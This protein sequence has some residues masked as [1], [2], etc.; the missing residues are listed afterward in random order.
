MK[1]RS[2]LG[3]TYRNPIL[4]A[5]YS[6]PDVIRVG[7]NF[8]MTA[9]SF[10]YTPGLPILVSKDLV[11]WELK[12]YALENIGQERFGIPRH[13]EGVWAPAI[14]YH[15][16]MFYIYYGMPDEGYYV[17]RTK[18]PLGKWEEPVCVLEGKGLIDPC[19]FRDDDGKAYIIHGYAKSRIGFKSIL[20]IFEMS[21]DGLKAVSE[22]HFIFDGNDPAHPAVTI[23]GPKVYKRNGYY[24]ILAP[25]G[26]VK[27]GYQVALRSRNIKGPYE[28][29]TVM[30][31]GS[32]VINGPHQGGLVDTPNGDE[33]FIHFQDRGLYG[34]ICHLQPASWEEDWPVI[35]PGGEPVYE[36]EKPACGRTSEMIADENV[37]ENASV[38]MDAAAENKKL[39]QDTFTGGEP[40]LEWQ[41]LG[42]HRSS[43]FGKA[44][45]D[46]RDPEEN[47]SGG[48]RLF[49]LNPSK[50]TEPILW[51]S[52]NVLTK[53]ICYPV[54]EEEICMD[55]A[56]LKIGERAGV[57]MMGG[58]Y[59]T[60]YIEKKD[61]GYYVCTAMSEGADADK[62]E[63]VLTRF[64]LEKLCA[65]MG[66]SE[67]E[68]A[69]KLKFIMTF[70]YKDRDFDSEELYFR[71]VDDPMF[72]ESPSLYIE[73]QVGEDEPA[74][75]GIKFTP[76][77]HTWVG[78]KTGIY[79]ISSSEEGGHGNV[80]E[81]SPGAAYGY[82]DFKSVVT[83]EL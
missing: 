50:D 56:G 74:D 15:E 13:S 27:Y 5:D 54:F 18:D 31:Q 47:L 81:V 59:V 65:K 75:L 44:A 22:D 19:P 62:K 9:S 82:A 68:A 37:S 53:K 52:V 60:A 77:D 58:Q 11:N 29:K 28:I 40:S 48:L 23:E 20:G 71:N 63:V 39:W 16:G 25:A 57:C 51:R 79:A 30:A 41:W 33:W 36:Y 35:G 49:S 83:K 32:S 10:N 67:D 70:T 73:L 55:A 2:D 21:S 61:D 72:G 3:K 64:R 8:Y 1:T 4:F 38:N 80:G 43:F 46:S 42:D 34:R 17:V 66:L 14:R 6:D 12:N 7:D 24:Y 78:A 45:G 26:G 69:R 76:S